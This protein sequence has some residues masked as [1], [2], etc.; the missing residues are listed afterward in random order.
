MIFTFIREKIEIS[1][2][3]KRSVNEIK[4]ISRRCSS[5]G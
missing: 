2:R 3:A 5:S 1:Q 4:N